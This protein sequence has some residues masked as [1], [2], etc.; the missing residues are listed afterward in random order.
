V[1]QAAALVIVEQP[2]LLAL[3]THHQ[4]HQVKEITAELELP[5][6]V[7]EV[8]EVVEVVLVQ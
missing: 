5:L 7:E 1:V 2:T 8:T 4:L 3:V 6:M